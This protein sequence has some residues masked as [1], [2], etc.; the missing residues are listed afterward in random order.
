[1]KLN[2]TRLKAK[3][4]SYGVKRDRIFFNVFPIFSHVFYVQISLFDVTFLGM[5]C[6]CLRERKEI[7]ENGAVD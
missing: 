4:T 2:N 7:R 1:M 6:V 5:L 3:Y